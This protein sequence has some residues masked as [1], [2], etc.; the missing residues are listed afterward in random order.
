MRS[1]AA[2]LLLSAAPAAACSGSSANLAAGQCLAWQALFDATGGKTWTKCAD[3]DDPCACG[4]SSCD[5]SQ[6]FVCVQCAADSITGIAL[7]NVGMEGTLPD[8]VSNLSFLTQLSLT[9]NALTGTIPATGVAKL[10]ALTGLYLANTEM[11]GTL[12]GSV[13]GLSNLVFLILNNNKFSGPVPPSLASLS[14]LR[15]I[16]LWGNQFDG[17]LPELPFGQYDI[18]CF[19]DH[20]GACAEPACNHF[21]C[22]L[23]ANASA[24]HVQSAG[25]NAGVHCK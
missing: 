22:P 13:G 6:D 1:W 3:R 25:S 12:P 2:A 14:Q 18:D 17:A 4:G 24:C 16:S 21:D 5:A 11:T 9:K 8:A 19:L 20:P 15:M 23:P 7:S 10:T